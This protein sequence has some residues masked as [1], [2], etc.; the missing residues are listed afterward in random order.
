[1]EQLRTYKYLFGLEC[2]NSLGC[3]FSMPHYS[4]PNLKGSTA[5]KGGGLFE[6]RGEDEVEFCHR[7]GEPVR[8]GELKAML[9]GVRFFGD[10]FGASQK[11]DWLSGHP[12]L[13]KV[14]CSQT[15]FNQGCVLHFSHELFR[16]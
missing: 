12:R 6:S 16:P 9:S 1:M 8:F 13:A 15:I 7:A 10:F 14:K 4:M 2:F 11:S 5:K 3:G